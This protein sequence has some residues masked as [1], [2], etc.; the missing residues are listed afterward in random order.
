MCGVFLLS[1]SECVS[2]W[3]TSSKMYPLCFPLIDAEVTVPKNSKYLIN[4]HRNIIEHIKF[5]LQMH[6]RLCA[7]VCM[8]NQDDQAVFSELMNPSLMVGASLIHSYDKILHK[9]RY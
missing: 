1:M 6:V 7:G 4:I 5:I 2:M 3:G 8:Q 9:G